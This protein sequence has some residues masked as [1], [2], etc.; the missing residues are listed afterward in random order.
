MPQTI[1]I[2]AVV[3]GIIIV[4]FLFARKWRQAAE[5]GVNEVAGICSFAFNQTIRKNA[6]KEKIIAFIAKRVEASNMEIRQAL[7]FDDRSVVR[8]MTELEKQGRVTQVG[9]TGRAVRYRLTPPR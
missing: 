4:A 5:A 2:I 1:L 7:G 8:Y 6:N 3:I 9:E